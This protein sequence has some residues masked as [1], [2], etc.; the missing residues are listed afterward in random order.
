MIRSWPVGTGP[1]VHGFDV[2]DL[3]AAEVAD[4]GA[5]AVSAHVHGVDR[6][7]RCQL[8]G[9][10]RELGLAVPADHAVGQDHGRQVGAG[11]AQPGPGDLARRPGW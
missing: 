8:L 10:H 2:V 3:Q 9:E 5:L 7:P 4:A 1:L 11:F 6:E